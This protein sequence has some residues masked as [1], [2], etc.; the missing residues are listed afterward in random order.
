MKIC[1]KMSFFDIKKSNFS[2]CQAEFQTFIKIFEKFLKKV[3]T[4]RFLSAKMITVII[5]DNE[6]MIAERR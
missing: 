1:K 3:L 2:A 6:M 5:T 4:N